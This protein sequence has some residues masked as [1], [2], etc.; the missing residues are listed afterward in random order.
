MQK[1]LRHVSKE[2][3]PDSQDLLSG[4]ELR[5]HLAN[6]G[7]PA[8]SLVV[9][10]DIMLAGRSRRFIT[11]NGP[12]YPFRAVQPILERSPIVVGNLEGPLTRRPRSPSTRNF[13]YRLKPELAG[14]LKEAGFKVVALAN[15]HLLDCG[16]QGVL[17][18]LDALTQVGLHPIGAGADEKSAYNPIL[19]IADGKR[20]GLLNYYWNPRTAAKEKRAGSAKDTPEKLREGIRE[21]KREANKVVTI[22]HWGIP[23]E[24]EPLPEDR[25]KA[26]YAI[27]CGADAVIGHHPH[28]LQPFEIYHGRPIF[29][30]VGNF[31]FGSANSRAEGVAIGLSF[32]D[33]E[34]G[35][36]VF[37]LYVKNRDPRVAY[38][39]KVV[40][41]EAARRNLSRL[42]SRSAESGKMLRI[43]DGV[44]KLNL[45]L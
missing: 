44:G 38:Q 41:G 34:T 25:V 21:L 18:T 19:Q 5:I 24:R 23:Y 29:Y 9:V 17:D 45:P 36:L 11:Q 22:F 28:V 43:E 7:E 15:N 26:R 37:P 32:D 12:G 10:G 33:D 2:E 1:L 40:S 27:D 13:S 8:P 31:T 35:A 20:I 42:A 3:I 30:S 6:L 16:R 14:S 4:D 39:P